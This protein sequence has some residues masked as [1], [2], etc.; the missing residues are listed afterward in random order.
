[1]IKIRT[2]ITINAPIEAVWEVMSDMN[3]WGGREIKNSLLLCCVDSINMLP[4]FARMEQVD[5]V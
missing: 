5:Q 3:S 2:S 4:T 1:M